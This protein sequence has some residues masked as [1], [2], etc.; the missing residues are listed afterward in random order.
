[1]WTQLCRFSLL[2]S[3]RSSKC[4]QVL[5][6]RPIARCF[7]AGPSPP[8]AEVNEYLDSLYSRLS[9]HHHYTFLDREYQSGQNSTT[10]PVENAKHL[11][12]GPLIDAI[13]SADGAVSVESAEELEKVCLQKFQAWSREAQLRVG[14]LMYLDSRINST[15]YLKKVVKHIGSGNLYDLQAQEVVA[16]L[17]LIYFKRHWSLEELCDILDVS[18]VQQVLMQ[19]MN[20]EELSRDEITAACLGLRR[21]KGLAINVHGF[22]DSLYRE[23]SKLKV[24]TDPLDDLFVVQV[25]TT[26]NMENFTF[27]DGKEKVKAA[28]GSLSEVAEDL[29]L[30]TAIKTMGFGISMGVYDEGL[31][32]RVLDR[33]VDNF[34]NISTKDV[35]NICAFLS[36]TEIGDDA[37]LNALVK[38]VCR[39]E[40]K[41][42]T[43]SDLLDVL[44]AASYL[45]HR[46]VYDQEFVNKVALSVNELDRAQL[47]TDLTSIGHNIALNIFKSLYPQSFSNLSMESETEVILA[48]ASTF[49]RIPVFLCESFR[50]LRPNLKTSAEI[51]VFHSHAISALLHSALPIEIYSPHLK[52]NKL[53][54][55]WRLYVNCYRGMVKVL[56]SEHYVGAVRILPHFPE[57]DIVFGHIGGNQLTVP[58]YMSDTNFRGPRPAP[59]GEW[60]ALVMATRKTLGQDD[61]MTGIEASKMRQLE[62]LGYKPVVVPYTAVK[63]PHSIGNVLKD[64]LMMNSVDMP[65][66]FRGL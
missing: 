43:F 7:S 56:G 2:R 40:D 19:K 15:E 46:N 33:V 3:L 38:R 24:A 29:S 65:D 6:V 41:S 10:K 51:E 54:N 9:S 5:N 1:M 62:E 48:E 35:L 13:A 49:A 64:L 42:R 16:L 53:K 57:P 8:V 22:R 36:K 31:T 27:H 20:K 55:R 63:N 11:D 39:L 4:R 21:V 32:N 17:L 30:P 37:F 12:L 60:I 23:I 44:K 59:A 34:S 25:L 14:F 50:I 18:D 58:S 61:K 45:G 47:T 28:M 52:I 26:L 66:H